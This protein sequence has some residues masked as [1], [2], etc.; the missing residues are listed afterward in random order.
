MKKQNIK[1]KKEK[2]FSFL[3]I[4]LILSLWETFSRYGFIS[5]FFFPSPWKILQTTYFLFIDGTLISHLVV[6]LQ[7]LS[8]GFLLGSSVGFFL[9]MLMGYSSF[10][11]GVI[12]P[13]VAAIHPIPK[14]AL[15]PLIMAILGIGESSKIFS[16]ALS[17][18]FPMV[19]N[20]MTGVILIPQDYYEIARSYGANRYYIFRRVILPASMPTT[21]S[22]V[23]LAL[24][25]SLVTVIAVEMISA[26]KGL[27]I[28]IWYAWETLHIEHLYATLIVISLLGSSFNWIIKILYRLFIPW[29]ES[30]T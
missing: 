16:I 22:G 15:L 21:L 11:R 10:V 12:D 3:F 18:F 25:M 13:F 28:M 7:R 1:N 29:K 9:G 8:T 4:L 19:I 14:I 27:G 24:N 17:S 26:K 2:W 5:S 6:T 20:T 23:R 30:P